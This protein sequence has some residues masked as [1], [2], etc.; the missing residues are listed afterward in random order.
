MLH[1]QTTDAEQKPTT[2]QYDANNNLI[3]EVDPLFNTNKFAYDAFRH[4]TART[5][6]LGQV[7]RSTYTTNGLLS[8]T[9]D[10]RSTR[11]RTSTAVSICS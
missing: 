1:N 8:S 6:A 3:E 4:L 5:N 2:R 11:P 10:A 9:T 7:T